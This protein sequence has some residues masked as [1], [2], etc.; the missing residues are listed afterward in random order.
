MKQ[1]PTWWHDAVVYQVYPRSFADSNGDG[2]GD[3]QGIINRTPYLSSLGINAIWLSPFYPSDLADGGYDVIDYRDVD[4]KIG[5]LTDFKLLV[6]TVH[7]HGLK[8]I[9]DIVP[10]HS[11]NNH[12]WF[13]EALNSPAGSKAR[14]RYIFRDGKGENGEIPPNSWPSH[15]GPTCWTRVPDG[16]WYLH[17]FAPEQPD[18]NWDNEEVRL[19]FE[20]TLRFWSDLGVDGFRIDVAHGLTKDMSEPYPEI[21]TFA[22]ETYPS[23]GSHPLFDR[24]EVHTIY[25]RWREI[26]NEYNPPKF[27]VAE[28][29]APFDRKFRYALP[30]NLGQAF[31]FE[32]MHAHW[33]AKEFFDTIKKCLAMAQESHSTT[34]WVLSNHDVIRHVTRYGLP[35]DLDLPQ[36]LL[37]NGSSTAVDLTLG[38]ARARAA[39]LLE[40]ALPG[41]SYLYQGEELGLPE[42]ADLPPEVLADPVWI[43]SG[44]LQK[45]RDGCRV[46]LPWDS[47]LVNCGFSTGKP[48]LPLPD[49]FREL[50]VE[51]QDADPQ[52]T[53]NLYRNALQLRSELLL[54]LADAADI[55]NFHWI[56]T[57]DKEV[58]HVSRG[59]W[60]CVINFSDHAVAF[61]T[62][63]VLLSSQAYSVN[64]I[65]ANTALWIVR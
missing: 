60:E 10:N 33:S 23:D 17:L 28:S 58:L 55:S 62:S 61:D 50:S 47:H 54:E 37:S 34:T 43:R 21:T 30:N 3:L 36:W 5:S 7:E 29:A 8:L 64:E 20:K 48:H 51:I 40:L 56:E 52:S 22:S 31:S 14:D 2:I 42:V 41:S 1:A 45:G 53:L 12:A 11:S 16:Q 27:A 13:Q 39:I 18:F 25:E 15:F 57:S 24:D 6:T 46:P 9:I 59:K 65:P 38:L 26:F 19:D 35:Q 49:N 63:K 32:F 4:P 44:H